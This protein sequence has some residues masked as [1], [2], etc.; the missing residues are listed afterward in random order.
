MRATTIRLL[1][2][3]LWLIDEEFRQNPRN[4]RLFLEIAACAGRRDARAAPHEPVRRAR[5]LHPGVRPRRRAHAVRPVPRLYRRCAHAVR[6]AQPAPPR[7][8]ALRARAARDVA[9]HGNRCSSPRSSISPRC[10]TTS[11]RAAAA[12][13]PSSARVDAEAFCLEQ[14]LSRYDARLVAWLVRNHLLFS[15]TAQKK[16]ISRS[17][18]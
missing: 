7:A 8:A 5:P 4:H 11:P 9:A 1:G 10:S 3:H 2:R 6:G 12:T 18:R 15:V 13:T 16:D 17:R 14:G